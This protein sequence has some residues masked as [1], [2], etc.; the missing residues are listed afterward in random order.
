MMQNKT[1][2]SPGFIFNGNLLLSRIFA[3]KELPFLIYERRSKFEWS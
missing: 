1:F 3:P 2:C